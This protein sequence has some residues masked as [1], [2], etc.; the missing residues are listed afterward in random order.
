M[1]SHWKAPMRLPRQANSLSIGF[2]AK[3]ARLHAMH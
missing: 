1:D 3:F 2:D